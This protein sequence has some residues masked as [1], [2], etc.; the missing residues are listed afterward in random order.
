[1]QDLNTSETTEDRIGDEEKLEA[2]YKI[3]LPCENCE[4]VYVGE[5]E[6]LLGKLKVK[7]RRKRLS[8]L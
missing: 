7:E 4:R 3:G 8:A 1:L 5:T 2:V 6:I